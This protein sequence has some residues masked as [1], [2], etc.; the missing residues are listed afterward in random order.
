MGK[1]REWVFEHVSLVVCKK[2]ASKQIDAAKSSWGTSLP[3]EF[4]FE[5]N[6]FVGRYGELSRN[7][8]LLLTTATHT[9]LW[10]FAIEPIETC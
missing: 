3:M 5:F 10:Y 9:A 4:S 1:E 7:Y 8:V 6:R 2:Q